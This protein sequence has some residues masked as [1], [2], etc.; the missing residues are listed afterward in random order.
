MSLSKITGFDK[1]HVNYV[2]SFQLQISE[3][4]QGPTK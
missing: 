3:L 1:L 2:G 4:E